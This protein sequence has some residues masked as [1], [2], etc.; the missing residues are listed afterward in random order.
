MTTNKLFSSF[1]IPDSN[2]PAKQERYY[3]LSALH[4]LLIFTYLYDLIKLIPLSFQGWIPPT[5]A[6]IIVLVAS[7]VFAL[8][9]TTDPIPQKIPGSIMIVYGAACIFPGN[10]NF[11]LGTYFEESFS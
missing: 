11:L 8:I 1:Y 9:H 10:F 3:C 7:A 2:G 5:L 6:I 4:I